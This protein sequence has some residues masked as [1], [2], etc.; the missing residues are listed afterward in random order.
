MKTIDCA[1][2]RSLFVGLISSR[3]IGFIFD[4]HF[5]CVLSVLFDLQSLSFVGGLK[6]DYLYLIDNF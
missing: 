2:L 6:A 5:T 1:S 4:G 3:G